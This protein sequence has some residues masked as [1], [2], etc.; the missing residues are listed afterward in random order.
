MHVKE[1]WLPGFNA[2]GVRTASDLID[3]AVK[4]IDGPDSAG[5]TTL[6][7]EP[8]R[9]RKLANAFNAVQLMSIGGEDPRYEAFNSGSVLENAAADLDG[10][11]KA[12][13]EAAESLDADKPETL[14]NIVK[15]RQSLT[16]ISEDNVNAAISACAAVHSALEAAGETDDELLDQWKAGDGAIAVKLTALDEDRK[17][18]SAALAGEKVTR[19]K[20]K[21]ADESQKE[22]AQ[23][24]LEETKKTVVALSAAAKAAVETTGAAQEKVAEKYK[25]TQHKTV[26][27]KAETALEAVSSLATAAAEANDV[28]TALKADDEKTWDNILVAK[29]KLDKV[30]Q[31]ID[32]VEESRSETLKKLKA[33]TAPESYAVAQARQKLE[34]L[35]VTGAKDK[36]GE[37]QIAY[38]ALSA[39]ETGELEDAK[40]KVTE[41]NTALK[42]LKKEAEN[43]AKDAV[44][45]SLPLQM[46][47]DILNIMLSAMERDPNITHVRTFWEVRHRE[48]LR[49]VAT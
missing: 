47:E 39:D 6:K 1:L 44:N 17:K 36:T 16:D 43:A 28:A 42:S 49:A 38:E 19:Q 7:I 4:P 10:A 25:D 2:L 22:V 30:I 31:A 34:A 35:S 23:E 26:V 15:L 32:K 12:A 27:E 5:I 37:A 45:A 8:E 14:D 11:R 29:D 3:Y 9:V 46:T 18:A 21:A 48:A 33:L 24:G 13:K 20:L 41:A 40:K